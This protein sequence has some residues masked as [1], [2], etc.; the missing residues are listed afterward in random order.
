MTDA[1]VVFMTAPDVAVAED[2]VRTL[3]AERLDAVRGAVGR[4]GGEDA[5]CSVRNIEERAHEMKVAVDDHCPH[6]IRPGQRHAGLHRP[7][8]TGWPGRSRCCS[9]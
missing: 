8:G 5:V 1:R 2:I 4:D 7:A 6:D 9:G 3:V